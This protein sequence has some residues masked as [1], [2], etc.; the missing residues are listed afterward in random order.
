MINQH[1]GE[2]CEEGGVEGGEASPF[3]FARLVLD[4]NASRDAREIEEDKEHEGE[5][6]KSGHAAGGDVAVIEHSHGAGNNLLG[7]HTGNEGDTFFPCQSAGTD[8]RLY[9]LADLSNVTDFHLLLL[10]HFCMMWK[11]AECPHGN[12]GNEDGCTHLL[13][14]LLAFFPCVPNNAFC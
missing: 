1:G 4:A 8:D 10:G 14:I 6:G 2:P 9:E 3:P 5:G 12:A 7:S 13:E 11:V